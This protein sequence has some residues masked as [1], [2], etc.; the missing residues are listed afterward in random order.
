M[1]GSSFGFGENSN[2]SNGYGSEHG[3]GAGNDVVAGP[4]DAQA[5]LEN[6]IGSGYGCGCLC[7]SGFDNSGKNLDGWGFSDSH[8]DFSNGSVYGEGHGEP[9]PCT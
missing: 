4:F 7:N 5:C 8:H 1:S 2:G 9:R 3:Y 6:E